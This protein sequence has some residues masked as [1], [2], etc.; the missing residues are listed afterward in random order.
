MAKCRLATC[1]RKAA[2]DGLCS[3]HEMKVLNRKTD[4]TPKGSVYVGRPGP[5]GNPFVVGKDG[6]RD[7]VLALHKLWLR[8]RMLDETN[9]IHGELSFLLGKDLVC[10]CA[11]LPCHGETLRQAALWS[12]GLVEEPP[13]KGVKAELRDANLLEQAKKT[14]ARVR[15]GQKRRGET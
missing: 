8:K 14:I 11:P 1:K 2:K 13:W 7:Q 4:G 10:W 6:D 15:E 3:K 12:A 9:E 5:W